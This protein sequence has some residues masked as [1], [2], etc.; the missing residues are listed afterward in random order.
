ML[1]DADRERV[2]RVMTAMMKMGKIDMAALQ[3]AHDAC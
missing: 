3:A 2:T 1:L